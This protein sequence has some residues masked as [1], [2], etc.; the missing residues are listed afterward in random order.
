MDRK[1][2]TIKIIPIIPAGGSP[3]GGG[4]IPGLGNLGVPIIFPAF[5]DN[6]DD[7]YS[8]EWDTISEMGRPD[9]KYMYKKFNRTVNF[10]FYIVVK[11]EVENITMPGALNSLASLTYP[12][13]KTG[14]GYNGPFAILSIGSFF[15]SA[16][17]FT[18]VS[19][20]I[21]AETPFYGSGP[22]QKPTLI[23]VSCA[24]QTIGLFRP[25][26]LRLLEV[27]AIQNAPTRYSLGGTT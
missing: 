11:N 13:F 19:W 2:A 4:G 18:S 7:Q 20:G 27:P 17:F 24:F 3:F 8:P 23:K 25:K 9:N 12:V 6:L 21:D 22:L 10:S 14:E 1:K 15:M 5:I 16:G 26:Y